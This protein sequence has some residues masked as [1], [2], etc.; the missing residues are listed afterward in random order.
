LPSGSAYAGRRSLRRLGPLCLSQAMT[1]I[2][3]SASSVWEGEEEFAKELAEVAKHKPP[4]SA[5][6]VSTITKLALKNLKHYKKIVHY[7]ERFINKVNAEYRLSGL[8]LVDS[9]CKA[10]QNKLG[11][12]DVFT[13]QFAKR[14]EETLNDAFECPPKDRDALRRVIN[15]WIQNKIFPDEV[16]QNI[17]RLVREKMEASGTT[18]VSATSQPPSAP[19][20]PSTPTPTSTSTYSTPST[21]TAT[22]SSQLVSSSAPSIGF[23]LPS[24]LQMLQQLLPQ[25]QQH[26][27]PNFAQLPQAQQEAIVQQFLQMA[28]SSMNGASPPLVVSFPPSG[29]SVPQPNPSG[30]L[31]PPSLSSSTDLQ[32]SASLGP[33]SLFSAPPGVSSVPLS[34]PSQWNPAPTVPMSGPSLGLPSSSS[35]LIGVNQTL[36]VPPPPSSSNPQPLSYPSSQ[37]SV[38]N[39]PAMSFSSV[40]TLSSAS[41]IDTAGGPKVVSGKKVD[42][43][44][45]FGDYDDDD[46]DDETRLAEQK[47]RREEEEQK[48]REEEQK[49][50]S[51]VS[52]SRLPQ[53]IK[54]TSLSP[55]SQAAQSPQHSLPTA[56][57]VTQ[58]AATTAPF[59]SS[60]SSTTSDGVGKGSPIAPSATLPSEPPLIKGYTF[61][62]VLPPCVCR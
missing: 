38:V 27:P 55:S 49:K 46:I 33:S 45:I 44:D 43:D 31:P 54:S 24:H 52:L 18:G 61:P 58:G 57:S 1:T 2:P 29:S 37:T 48:R 26:L 4:V 59:A 40:N 11:D 36:W 56:T 6:R 12:K 47:R 62:L 15:I 5:S 35:P 23:P 19:P 20:A 39:T 25:L 60:S 16:L 32:S 21:T 9:I 13:P 14:I 22:M 30:P 7:I 50:M 53:A 17:A 42:P 34:S 28:A 3:S 10:A 8:Y 41:S 51:E